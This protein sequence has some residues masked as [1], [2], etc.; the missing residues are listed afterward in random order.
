M[1]VYGTVE[2]EIQVL[3]MLLT[4]KDFIIWKGTLLFS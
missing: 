1:K 4:V 3:K 2:I